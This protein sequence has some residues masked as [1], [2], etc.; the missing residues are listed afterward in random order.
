[1]AYTPVYSVPFIQ[2]APAAPNFEFEVPEGATAIIRQVSVSAAIVSGL[3]AVNIQDSSLAPTVTID[4]HTLAGIYETVHQE[5]RWV[6]PGGGIISFYQE[7]IGDEF[8]AYI[9]GYLLPNTLP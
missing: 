8:Y 2:S 3:Y 1:M 6:V 9:G 4:Q 5:G 7:Y